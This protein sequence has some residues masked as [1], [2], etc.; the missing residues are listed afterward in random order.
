M[1]DPSEPMIVPALVRLDVSLGSDKTEVIRALAAQVGE[2]GRTQDPDRLA[3]DALAR[4]STSAT[5]LPGKVEPVLDQII[6]RLHAFGLASH[7]DII[8]QGSWL[9]AQPEWIESERE[10]LADDPTALADMERIH[11][12]R[13]MGL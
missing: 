1:T 13:A 6:R 11:A 8:N 2:A 12:L 4:E 7:L 5:G 10:H 3:Q 9:Q